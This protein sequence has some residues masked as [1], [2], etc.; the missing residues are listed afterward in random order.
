MTPPSK[1]NAFFATICDIVDDPARWIMSQLTP[2]VPRFDL[3]HSLRNMRRS[4][5]R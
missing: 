5:E 1:G 4:T 2:R 3:P